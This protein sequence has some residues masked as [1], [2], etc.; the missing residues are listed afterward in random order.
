MYGLN[1][2]Y[3]NVVIFDGIFQLLYGWYASFTAV[4]NINMHA[5][6]VFFYTISSF[7]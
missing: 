4:Y 2:V 5:E 3:I 7:L 1:T 6:M